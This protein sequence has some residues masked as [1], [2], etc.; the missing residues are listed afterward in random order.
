MRGGRLST[1]W[2]GPT[3]LLLCALSLQATTIPADLQAHA[4]ALSKTASPPVLAWVHDEGGRLAKATGPVDVSALEAKIRSQ[5]T[6]AQTSRSAVV[7]SMNGADIEALA[8]LVLM[9]ASKSA[10]EDLKAI[11]AG[12]QAT[13]NAK[14]QQ[15]KLLAVQ[16]TVA[17]VPT[18]TPTPAPDRVAQ[19]LTAARGVEA[20]IGRADLS[21][22]A[23]R[24]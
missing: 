9:D 10:Q 19:L 11:M 1:A 24:P 2:A 13:N 23:L 21:H 14:A 6:F 8:F 22:V 15:R 17:E 3:A 20:K 12:V 18:K 7:G 4:D 5:F 16:Q